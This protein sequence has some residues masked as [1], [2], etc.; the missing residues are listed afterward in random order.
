MS[1]GVNSSNKFDFALKKFELFDI[2]L[3]IL[4]IMAIS[5][6]LHGLF[7]DRKGPYTNFFAIFLL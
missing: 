5:A 3:Q 7:Y 4:L 6:S 1:G 2:L